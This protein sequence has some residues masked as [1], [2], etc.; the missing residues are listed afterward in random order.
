MKRLVAYANNLTDYHA[1]LDLLPNLGTLYFDRRF[2]SDVKLSAVQ[3]AIL[4][5]LGLQRKSFE[6]VEVGLNIDRLCAL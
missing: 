4:L 1:I 2:G 5:A 6:D 3:C